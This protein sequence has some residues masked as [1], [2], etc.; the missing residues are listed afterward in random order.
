MALLVWRN[1]NT[2]DGS[3]N[4]AHVNRHPTCMVGRAILLVFRVCKLHE[5]VSCRPTKTSRPD[6]FGSL[7]ETV[8]VHQGSAQHSSVRSLSNVR[9]I[10]AAKHSHG[11]ISSSSPL[12][13]ATARSP[14]P[15][16]ALVQ[17]EVIF[18]VR[19][20]CW[21]KADWVSFQWYWKV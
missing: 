15:A 19:T 11:T 8:F 10:S 13:L 17:G 1:T 5:Q 3:Q 9:V 14:S 18:D 4:T 2:E 20:N 21:I 7:V 6:I 12:R 16:A